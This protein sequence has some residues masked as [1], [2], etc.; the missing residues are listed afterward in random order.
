VIEGFRAADNLSL[1]IRGGGREV[2]NSVE[3]E[4]VVLKPPNLS[5]SFGYVPAT[6]LIRSVPRATLNGPSFLTTRIA[7][8]LCWSKRVYFAKQRTKIASSNKVSEYL[9]K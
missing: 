7:S 9:L 1:F 8:C 4:R 2:C 6:G 3:G 5:F